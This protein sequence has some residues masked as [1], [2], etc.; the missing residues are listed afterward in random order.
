MSATPPPDTEGSFRVL[1]A[2]LMLVGA[3]V[4]ALGVLL[5]P[6]SGLGGAHIAAIGVSLFLSGAVSTRWAATRFDLSPAEQRR[7]SL[8]FATLAGLLVVLLVVLNWAT[9]ETGETITEG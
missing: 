5:L 9:F 4:V 6:E 3:A 8:A 2:L 1:P 7:W